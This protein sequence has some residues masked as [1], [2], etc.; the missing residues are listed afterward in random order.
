MKDATNR[1]ITIIN[2][3]FSYNVAEE[4]DTL[5]LLEFFGNI[6]LLN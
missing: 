6:M 4:E 5:K 2:S 3:N 1:L